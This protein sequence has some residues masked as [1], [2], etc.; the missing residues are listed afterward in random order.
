MT[1]FDVAHNPSAC[2]NLARK[3]R[4]RYANNII[5]AVV[6]M[7]KDKDI[8]RSLDNMIPVVD[9][10]YVA[11]LPG[12]RGAEGERLQKHL[13]AKEVESVQHHQSITAAYQ[14]CQAAALPGSVILVFGSFLTVAEAMQN[15]A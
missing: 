4:E 1:I 10:W 8:E 14:A 12:E 7:L 6:G 5:H 11:N 9:C 3:I 13:R 15:S 2:L